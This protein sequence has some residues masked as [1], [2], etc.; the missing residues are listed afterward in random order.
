MLKPPVFQTTSVPQQSV[1]CGRI[2]H[3]IVV[4]PTHLPP[5]M[6]R[7]EMSYRC[8]EC[9]TS[10]ERGQKMLKRIIFRTVRYPHGTQGTQISREIKLCPDCMG[11]QA[12]ADRLAG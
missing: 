8:D 10:T 4:K 5:V 9:K 2:D 3:W 12:G 11:R 7:I 1:D 6:R